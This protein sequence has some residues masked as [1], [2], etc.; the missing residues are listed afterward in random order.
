[1]IA[2]ACFL[3]VGCGTGSSQTADTST[4][5]LDVEELH[6]KV[7]AGEDVYLLDVRTPREYNHERLPFTDA[8]I[9]CNQLR[10]N[11]ETLPSDTTTRI[12]TFCRT[13]RRSAIAAEILPKLGYPD[14]INVKGGITAWKREGCTTEGKGID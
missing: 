4:G 1:M 13:G 14:V 9:P 8:L 10:A 3:L 6:A 12:Y 7:Q 11:L 2:A 5:N